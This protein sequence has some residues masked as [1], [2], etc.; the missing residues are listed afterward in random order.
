MI[1]LKHQI[2]WIF[3]LKCQLV[4]CQQWGN[5]Q[6]IFCCTRPS[7]VAW[8]ISW[9]TAHSSLPCLRCP[10]DIPFQCIF[11]SKMIFLFLECL[12]CPTCPSVTSPSDE[13][14]KKQIYLRDISQVPNPSPPQS[15]GLFCSSKQISPS[16]WYVPALWPGKPCLVLQS[17][18]FNVFVS[19]L[20]WV[21]ILFTTFSGYGTQCLAHTFWSRVG[22]HSVVELNSVLWV[23]MFYE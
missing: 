7:W 23:G 2:L 11:F 16:P 9:G 21:Y 5:V 14:G 20:V 12:L 18:F 8:L 1:F 15:L 13:G 17:L 19:F 6:T 3:Y 4:P 10:W 22:G